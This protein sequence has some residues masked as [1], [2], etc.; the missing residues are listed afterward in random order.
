LVWAFAI[1]T[2]PMSAMRTAIVMKVF[3][4]LPDTPF[5]DRQVL[6]IDSSLPAS[7]MQINKK[8]LRAPGCTVFNFEHHC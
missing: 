1:D 4:L 3:I 2:L 8:I 5:L 6:K 7:L